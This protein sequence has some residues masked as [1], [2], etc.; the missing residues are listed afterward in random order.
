[1]GFEGCQTTGLNRQKDGFSLHHPGFRRSM[2]VVSLH[3][4]RKNRGYNLRLTACVKPNR[5]EYG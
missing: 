5:G 1:M 3:F 2:S 4:N